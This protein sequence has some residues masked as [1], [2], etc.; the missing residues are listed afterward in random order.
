MDTA[1]PWFDYNQ[2]IVNAIAPI[3]DQSW[4]LYLADRLTAS[5]ARHVMLI[6]Y[7]VSIPIS[8]RVDV[9]GPII[10]SLALVLAWFCFYRNWDF[11]LMSFYGSYLITKSTLM[12]FGNASI[13]LTIPGVQ[14]DTYSISLNIAKLAT[15]VAC[16]AIL[17]I[18]GWSIMFCA[19]PFQGFSAFAQAIIATTCVVAIVIGLDNL[20][21]SRTRHSSQYHALESQEMVSDAQIDENT[22]SLYEDSG[23]LASGKVIRLIKLLPRKEGEE[24]RLEL[25]NKDLDNPKIWKWEAISYTWGDTHEQAIVR[26]D[27]RLVR[28]SQKVLT[29]FQALRYEWDPRFLWID[30]LCI[31]Q[32]HNIEKSHQVSI[33]RHIYHRAFSATLWLDPSPDVDV[34]IDLLVEIA[35]TPGLTGLHAA[36]LYGQPHQRHRLLA[37]SRFMENDY[38]NRLWVVQELASAQKLQIVC[39]NRV[40]Q[41]EDLEAVIIFLRNPEMIGLLQKTEEMGIV[42]CNQDTIRHAGSILSSRGLVVTDHCYSLAAVLLSYRTMKCKDPRDKVFALL[43][44]VRDTEH[45]LIRP[46]Y[47]K[48][49]IQVYRDVAEYIFTVEGTSRKLITLGVAGVGHCRRLQ[50][51]PSWVPDWASNARISQLDDRPDPQPS[52]YSYHV[53]AWGE[54]GNGLDL[55]KPGQSH[56]EQSDRALGYRA[57]LDI[58]P[59][60]RMVEDDVLGI[61]GFV[62]DEVAKLSSVFDMPFDETMRISHTAMTLAMLAWFEEAEA[63]AVSVPTPYPTGQPM[64]EVVWRTLLGDRLLGRLD[65]EMIRPAPSDYGELYQSL[66]GA[67]L[68]LRR[69]CSFMSV[70]VVTEMRDIWNQNFLQI[71][72]G[73]ST[74]KILFEVICG[75][76][77]HPHVWELMTR[78]TPFAND[79]VPRPNFAVDESDG[80]S[81]EERLDELGQHEE[82]VPLFNVLLGLIAAF[83]P[84]QPANSD[85]TSG[86]DL[87]EQHIAGAVHQAPMVAHFFESLRVGFKRRLCVTKKGY[88]G[89]VPPLTQVG[90]VVTIVHGGDAPYLVRPETDLVVAEKIGV[91]RCKLVGE[92]YMHGMMDGEMVGPENAPLWFHLA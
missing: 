27:G 15:Y 77:G 3:I 35:R 58:K 81:W 50:E 38:F 59:E 44:L 34:A 65:S 16:W 7:I 8:A 21:A 87:A 14:W 73:G 86:A 67:G 64:E 82:M 55:E 26:V 85:G 23:Q 52:S 12:T 60:V 46:D 22:A 4:M 17:S 30:Y 51:L 42:A 92:C 40:I 84:L 25:V 11:S 47:S 75:R 6:V 20:T 68:D 83:A 91:L 18:T 69:V 89:M 80:R 45:P 66:K 54:Y 74:Y 43:G 79:G 70:E 62:V 32:G 48:S 41:W 33:M 2:A 76:S 29:I 57:S 88:M 63:L 72:G 90:D 19:I 24:V 53:Q 61:R 5:P 71:I 13:W 39:G 56:F 28:I 78:G 49:E 9:R 36:H 1:D 10:Q 37:F 31:N